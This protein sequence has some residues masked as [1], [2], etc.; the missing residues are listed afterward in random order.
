V[1]RVGTELRIHRDRTLRAQVTKTFP[2]AIA[3]PLRPQHGERALVIAMS[4]RSL[5][6]A[7]IL[8]RSCRGGAISRCVAMGRLT[9]KRWASNDR[10]GGD[11]ERPFYLQLQDSIYERVQKEKAEQLRIQSLQQ[12]TAR[13]QFFATVTGIQVKVRQSRYHTKNQQHASSQQHWAT[14]LAN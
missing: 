10:K 8:P 3:P 2:A 11:D 4:L 13:G 9:Q 14:T 1:F 6:R 12:R 7:L 5:P